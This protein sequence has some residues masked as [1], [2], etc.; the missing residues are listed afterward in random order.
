MCAATADSSFKTT[1]TISRVWTRPSCCVLT[2]HVSSM[3]EH[4]YQLSL[5]CSYNKWTNTT[6]SLV[7]ST[8]FQVQGRQPTSPRSRL[9]YLSDFSGTR[10]T[11]RNSSGSRNLILSKQTLVLMHTLARRHSKTREP[12][13]EHLARRICSEGSSLEHVGLLEQVLIVRVVFSPYSQ[14]L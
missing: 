9:N 2:V 6:N 3:I 12:M 7:G 14:C 4:H 11:S 10:N 13:P 8:T 1:F 5:V